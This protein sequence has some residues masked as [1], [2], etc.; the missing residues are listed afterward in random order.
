[1]ETS[2]SQPPDGSKAPLVQRALV[3]TTSLV[4]EGNSSKQSS[5]KDNVYSWAG[6]EL[7]PCCI[8]W[9]QENVSILFHPPHSLISN[10]NKITTK[11]PFP[12]TRNCYLFQ[13]SHIISP[14]F[15]LSSPHPETQP[16]CSIRS[17]LSNCSYYVL[18]II[19][20]ILSMTFHKLH[21]KCASGVE[22]FSLCII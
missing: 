14:A 5:L 1:M 15:P 13:F 11:Q 4:T 10:E 22:N 7:A 3:L 2:H 16:Q 20:S 6:H 9:I 12:G 17:F 21:C 8:S 19:H 18:Q